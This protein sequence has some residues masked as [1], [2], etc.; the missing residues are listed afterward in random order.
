VTLFVKKVVAIF[1]HAD[2]PDAL[3]PVLADKVFFRAGDWS[4]IPGAKI[5]LTAPEARGNRVKFI[6]L[7]PILYCGQSS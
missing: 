2:A 4:K 7:Y 1:K 6:S 3:P 5:E